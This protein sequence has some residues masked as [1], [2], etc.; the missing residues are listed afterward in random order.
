MLSLRQSLTY[1]DQIRGD[2]GQG[3]TAEVGSHGGSRCVAIVCGWTT[4]LDLMMI[5]KVTKA[6]SG[7]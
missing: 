6:S 7:K 3:S 4:R 5:M 1:I 2:T